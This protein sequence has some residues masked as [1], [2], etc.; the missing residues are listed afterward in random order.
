MTMTSAPE[1]AMTPTS[2]LKSVAT[3]LRSSATHLFGK[4]ERSREVR[5]PRFRR[6]PEVCPEESA[7]DVLLIGFDHRIRLDAESP[8]N[9]SI[10]WL[11]CHD[12]NLSTYSLPSF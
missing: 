5:P 1:V 6:T 11:V 10:I 4:T 9:R 2:P 3:C 7:V 12:F 8:K